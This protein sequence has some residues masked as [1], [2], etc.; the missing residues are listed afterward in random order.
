MRHVMWPAEMAQV[1]LHGG[2]VGARDPPWRPPESHACRPIDKLGDAFKIG[3]MLAA[4]VDNK[5]CAEVLDLH[6]G[7]ARFKGLEHFKESLINF[8]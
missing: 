1:P 2:P 6:G 3:G 8:P 7:R 4:S 5:I